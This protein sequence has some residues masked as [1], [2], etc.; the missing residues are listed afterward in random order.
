MR[1]ARFKNHPEL[2]EVARQK[3][4]RTSVEGYIYGPMAF[5]KRQ[6]VTPRLSEIK[7]PTLIY[8]GEEDVTFA[9]AVK[10][11]HR[12]EGQGTIGVGADI[13]DGRI[14]NQIGIAGGRGD[15]ERLILVGGAGGDAVQIHRLQ[16]GVF[17][18]RQVVD[19]VQRRRL[20]HR[21]DRHRERLG[22]NVVA[23][24][25]IIDGDGD[26]WPSHWHWSPA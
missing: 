3:V 22:D 14:G 1:I 25:A 21:A 6:P 17:I 10:V 20:I 4:L 18:D 24:A 12:R 8:C 19:G 26:K 13:L 2:R 16:A 23:G 7:I 9:W 15:G 11:G 5:P